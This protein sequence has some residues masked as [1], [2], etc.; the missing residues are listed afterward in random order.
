MRQLF[1]PE[2]VAV[3]GV[4]EREDNMGR[5]IVENLLN[6]AYRG[7]VYAVGTRGGRV[8]YVEIASSV[9]ELPEGVEVATFLTPARTVPDLLDRCGAK[10]VRWAVVESAGF[11]ELSAEG[12]AMEEK[13]LAVAKKWGIRIVGPN[14]IGVMNAHTGLVLS[15][16]PIR[17]EAMRKGKVAI[18]AQSGG[19]VLALIYLL[20]E[21]GLGVSKVVSMGNKLDLDEV[22]YIPYLSSDEDTDVIVLFLESLDRG[23]ELMEVA[24]GCSK[25]V[26]V[27]KVN[28]Y[29]ASSL[30]ARYHTGALATDDAVVEAGLRQARFVRAPDLRTVVDYVKIFSLPPM[31][32]NGVVAIGRSGGLS[33]ATADA[34]QAEGFELERLSE[35]FIGAVEEGAGAHVI[36]RTNPLDLGDVFDFDFYTRVT[37]AALKEEGVNGIVF[38]HASAPGPETD[39]TVR[40]GRDLARLS[41]AY[42]K[43]IALCYIADEEGMRFVRGQLDFPLFREP[44][45]AL[46]ALRASLDY[47]RRIAHVGSE[48]LRL[49]IDCERVR[50]V[51]DRALAAGARDLW[52][53]EALEVLEAC[54]IETVPHFLASTQ[55][56]AVDKASAL[57]YPLVLKLNCPSVLHKSDVGGVVLGVCDAAAL[58][59]AFEDL[60]ARSRSLESPI[61]ARGVVVQRMMKGGVEVILGAKRDRSFGPVVVFGLGGIYAE[62]LRDVSLRVAPVTHREAREMIEELRGEE[63]LRGARG[64]VRVH[65]PS[66][67]EYIVR[68]SELMMSFPSI[69]GIDVNPLLGLAEERG[70]VAL[71]ARIVLEP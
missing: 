61:P 22:D 20:A 65:L 15:F 52:L 27:Q 33:I 44:T 40:L 59:Q 31:R 54:G 21:A 42:Q 4:S 68:L 47:H 38:N 49:S 19:V 36:A 28:I 58:V 6:H 5:N 13:L 46:G 57:G 18:V 25:P 16:S 7:E 55:E 45:E 37:E 69:Q 3:I 14:G 32:G 71:D 26:I 70:S 62:I 29:P 39:N 43:P 34:V 11:G 10:G 53:E 17:K 56:E 24:R 35:K 64:G 66:V 41:T 23:R 67:A 48:D 50:E 63:L 12:R 51:L 1:Y 30:I 8:R 2:R 9:E 60:M